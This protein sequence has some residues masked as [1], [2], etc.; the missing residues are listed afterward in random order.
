MAST[1]IDREM[2]MDLGSEL[3][4]DLGLPTPPKQS[5]PPPYPPGLSP[6]SE[7]G[8]RPGKRIEVPSA[9]L[10]TPSIINNYFRFQCQSLPEPTPRVMEIWD[11]ISNSVFP[12]ESHQKK[13]SHSTIRNE[14]R[15]IVT[16]TQIMPTHATSLNDIARKSGTRLG[17]S[18][19]PSVNYHSAPARV[20]VEQHRYLA[21]AVKT[22]RSI[23]PVQFSV[24]VLYKA[25]VSKEINNLCDFVQGVIGRIAR[26][27]ATN[28]RDNLRQHGNW[29]FRNAWRNV[30]A[31]AFFFFKAPLTELWIGEH[32]IQY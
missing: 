4:F 16:R 25:T 7:A 10:F 15:E 1:D 27:E 30:R 22:L 23:G 17:A 2:D 21:N 8:A 13:M 18:T 26:A 29:T 31:I 24:D 9:E 3:S 12:Q 20:N 5:T 28:L 14:E 19:H 11:G 32:K 6:N